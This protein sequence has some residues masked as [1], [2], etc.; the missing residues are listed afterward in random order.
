GTVAEMA[1]TDFSGPM[2]QYAQNTAPS[3][4]NG[5]ECGSFTGA[6]SLNDVDA[7]RQCVRKAF[8]ECRPA[9]YLL[10]QTAADGSRFV[11]YVAVEPTSFVSPACQLHVHTVSNDSSRFVGDSEKTCNT[12]DPLEA[13]ELACGIAPAG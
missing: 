10:D 11:S 4:L 12:L 5:V 6:S 9:R 2:D 1:P 13:I 8:S 7:G 3:E